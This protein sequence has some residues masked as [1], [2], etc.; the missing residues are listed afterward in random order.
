MLRIVPIEFK[1]ACAFVALHHRHHKP[2][3]GHKFSIGLADGE[4]VVGVAIVG[5]PVSR[6]LDDGWTL[7]VTRL[8]SDGT[9]NAPSKLYGACWR[10]VREMGY[11]RI[12]TYILDT[13]KGISLD[14]AGWRCMGQAGGLSWNT[15]S[16]PRVDASPQQMKIKYCKE[17]DPT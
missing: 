11:R 4:I 9:K 12:I 17:Q 5:R 15:P 16:R 10:V 8:C 3:Q 14:A 1:E 6:H 13:E 7:E 2:P